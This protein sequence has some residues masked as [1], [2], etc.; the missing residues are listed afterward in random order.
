MRNIASPFNRA[1]NAQ[2]IR[3]HTHWP[4]LKSNT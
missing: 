4:F 1:D 3:E 2:L